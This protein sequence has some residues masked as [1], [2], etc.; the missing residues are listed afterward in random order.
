MTEAKGNDRPHLIPDSK[1]PITLEKNPRRVIVKF[2]GKVIADT[3]NAIILKEASYPAVQYIPRADVD[4]QF[5][6]R[7]AHTSYCPYKGDA[8]YFNLSAPG[9]SSE[10]AIWSYEMPY[11]AVRAITN[12]VAFYPDR[13]EI[14]E[15]DP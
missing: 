11:E 10:N 4:M 6:Q 13:V 5:L 3:S 8:S 14:S 2:A 1:H 9:H 12:H 7:S 15:Q